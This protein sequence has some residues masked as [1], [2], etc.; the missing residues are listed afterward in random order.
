MPGHHGAQ[1][2]RIVYT[3]S[4]HSIVGEGVY[5]RGQATGDGARLEMNVMHV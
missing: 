2:R 3:G 4:E 1:Q 5:Q